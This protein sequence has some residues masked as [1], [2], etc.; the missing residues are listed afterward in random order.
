MTSS[1]LRRLAASKFVFLDRDGV[2]NRKPSEG[3]YI[4]NWEQFE[5]LPG[6][7]EAIAH[8]N[9]ARKRVLLV[10]N[11]RG[12]ALG[13]YSREDLDRIHRQLQNELASYGGHIDAI[14][15]CPHDSDQCNCRKPATGMLAQAFREFPD[16]NPSNSVIIGDSLSDIEAGLNLGMPSIF[17]SGD[18]NLQKPG[19]MR[20]AALATATSTSLLDAVSKYLLDN[21][22][23]SR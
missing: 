13:R 17:I 18:P 21:S 6:S 4:C 23:R 19:A 11:Q 3:Q 9:C 14:Y 15:Y 5:W 7:M 20:A 1:E 22:T 16:A 8:L 12:I 2:L 10:T